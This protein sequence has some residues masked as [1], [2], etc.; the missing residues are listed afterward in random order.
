MGNNN[1]DIAEGEEESLLVLDED[2]AASPV[3]KFTLYNG[4]WLSAK[5]GRE[6]KASGFNCGTAIPF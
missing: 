5:E 2:A 4:I 1:A 6:A 3:S